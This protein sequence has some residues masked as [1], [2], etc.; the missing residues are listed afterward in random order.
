MGLMVARGIIL[1]NWWSESKPTNTTWRTR[2]DH[3]HHF[4][5][6]RTAPEP[7]VGATMG[8]G[9][10][11]SSWQASLSESPSFFFPVPEVNISSLPLL[12]E[13]RLA[14]PLTKKHAC[15]CFFPGEYLMFLVW[16][17]VSGPQG[18]LRWLFN[19]FH[20]WIFGWNVHHRSARSNLLRLMSKT[21][22]YDD[23]CK[24]GPPNDS[25][26]GL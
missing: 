20:V 16:F 5:V 8:D 21:G 23:R 19:S 3:L 11:F 25:Q 18:A 12:V 9:N 17:P 4:P 15:F 22:F 6:L 1:V 24:V 14:R 10:L 2:H 26:V 7:S 13:N